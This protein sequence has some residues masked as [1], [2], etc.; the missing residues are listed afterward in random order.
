MAT[1]TTA[2][3]GNGRH[4]AGHEEFCQQYLVDLN[5]TAAYQRAYPDV[6]PSSA[7]AAGARLLA[8]VSVIDRIAQLQQERMERLRVS[9]DDVIRELLLLAQSDVRHFTVDQAGELHLKEGA[10]EDAWRAVSSVKHRTTTRGSGDDE[11]TVREVEYKLWDK[12]GCLRM[13]GEHL[14]MFKQILRHA[15]PDGSPLT[16]TQVHVYMPSNGRGGR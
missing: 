4:P 6:K 16:A 2:R 15:N 11:F 12:P 8:N 9:Q 5:A 7:R 14:A 10:P 3:N 13:L 1:R